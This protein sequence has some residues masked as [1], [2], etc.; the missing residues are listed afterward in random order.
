MGA[1]LEDIADETGYSIHTLYKFQQD[2]LYKKYLHG[3]FEKKATASLMFHTEAEK[4]VNEA[5]GDA[6]DFQ[7]DVM[8]DGS[9]STNNRLK[10]SDQIIKLTGMQPPSKHE[11]TEK[12]VHHLTF[13]D[14]GVDGQEADEWDDVD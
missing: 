13:V 14:S 6:I 5:L 9:V 7:L 8:K 2:P 4:K 12:Q 10:A 11:V 1:S 3:Q